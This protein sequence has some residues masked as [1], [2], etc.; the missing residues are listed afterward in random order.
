MNSI[1]FFCFF[2]F[3]WTSVFASLLNCFKKTIRSI[4]MIEQLFLIEWLPLISRFFFFFF[5][6]WLRYFQVPFFFFNSFMFFIFFHN[7]EKLAY[8]QG[9]A[10]SKT[11]PDIFYNLRSYPTPWTFDRLN[12]TTINSTIFNWT[13]SPSGTPA[14]TKALMQGQSNILFGFIFL[15]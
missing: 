8:P 7:L 4:K 10:R 9:V 11:Y 13:P 3:F 2:F 12:L 14:Y 1:Q 6:V 15:K 5:S